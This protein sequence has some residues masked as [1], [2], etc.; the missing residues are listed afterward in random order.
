MTTNPVHGPEAI[1]SA[2]LTGK[3]RRR[4]GWI[5]GGVLLA[6]AGAAAA[7]AV[8]RVLSAKLNRNESAAI[9]TLK[10]LSSAQAQMQASGMLDR[11]GNGSGEYAYFGELLG[12]VKL[13]GHDQ[14]MTPPVLSQA[15]QQV[16][17]GRLERSGY[18]F[19]MILPDAQL[20]A[21]REGPDGGR[22]GQ[23][24][25]V[26]PVQAEMLWACYAWPAS[27]GWSGRR[28]FFVNQNGDVLATNGSVRS[29]DGV[30]AAV[31]PDAAFA[32]SAGRHM[33]A[34]VAANTVGNDGNTWVVI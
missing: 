30:R 26:D 12:G 24:G 27:R 14:P 11:N 32:K 25:S 28:T 8:P 3:Q 21:V 20:Q 2:A 5:A 33:G 31:A 4:A 15:F 22:A 10:N 7:V 19:E 17:G 16:V 13:P 1:D 23:Q 9:A 29:Y 6:L 34:A 18:L